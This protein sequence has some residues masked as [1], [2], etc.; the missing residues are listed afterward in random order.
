MSSGRVLGAHGNFLMATKST[1][2][3]S[4]RSLT[5]NT[6]WRGN[7][8]VSGPRRRSFRTVLRVPAVVPRLPDLTR[9]SLTVLV[10]WG[11]TRPWP[12]QT[13]PPSIMIMAG[14]WEA[15]ICL[16][17]TQR[18]AYRRVF[19]RN[20][21]AL[22]LH[23]VQEEVVRLTATGGTGRALDTLRPCGQIP[24]WVNSIRHTLECYLNNR[25]KNNIRQQVPRVW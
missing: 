20:S 15:R 25:R 17:T 8:S 2:P 12:I 10:N 13:I 5:P 14:G 11:L 7:S 19:Y 18:A 23:L 9:C 3:D 1:S 24:L 21:I 6:Q 22:G 4:A 16:E